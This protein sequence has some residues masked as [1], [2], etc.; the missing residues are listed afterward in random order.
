MLCPVLVGREAE[1]ASLEAILAEVV[2]RSGRVALVGGDAGI[3]KSRLLDAFLARAR[4]SGARVV[5]GRCAQAEARRPFGP[6]IDSLRGLRDVPRLVPTEGDL[7][8]ADPDVRY[9]ALRSFASVLGDLARQ[10]PLVV[11]IDDLQWADDATMDLFAYLARALHERQVLL[12]ASYRTDELH[13]LHPLRGV[14]AAL[15]QARLADPVILR[16]LTLAGTR[17][18]VEA[19][20]GLTA[21]APREL[22]TALHERCEGNPFFT[23]EVLRALTETG[24]LIWRHGTWEHVGR[25]ADLVIPASVRDIVQERLAAL[26]NE[27]RV[28]LRVAAVIGISFDFPLLQRLTATNDQ[29]LTDALRAAVAAQLLEEV[30]E[31]GTDRFQF[32][33]ALTRESVLADLLGRERRELHREVAAALELRSGSESEP[34]ELAYHFD[35]AGEREPAFRY[36]VRASARAEKLFAF[37]NARKHLERALELASTD[38]DLAELQLRFS[39]AALWAGDARGALRAAEEARDAYEKRGDPRGI[40]LALC[41]ISDADWYLGQADEARRVAEE[42]VRVLESLGTP[43]ELGDAYRRMAQLALFDDDARTDWAERTIEAARRCGQPATEVIGLISLGGALGRQGRAEALGY[44]DDALRLALELDKPDLVFRARLFLLDVDAKLGASPIDRRA[45]YV[46]MIEHARKHAFSTDQVL[47]ME[48]EEAIALG[49]FDEALRLAGQVTPDSVYGAANDLLVAV[50]HIARSGPDKASEVDAPRRRLLSA[51]VLWQTFA[52]TTAQVFLLADQPRAALEDAELAKEHLRAGSQR[53]TVDVAVIS[54]I[55]SARRLADDAALEGWIAI[56]LD[57]ETAAESLVR[58]ARRAFAGAERARREG[59]LGRALELS[60][61]SVDA[62]DH[63][64][65]PVIETVARLRHAEL[66]LER[67]SPEDRA[68]ASAELSKVVAFWRRA[69]APWY[70]GRLRDWAREHRLRLPAAPVSEVRS[71]GIL[72][73]RE[74]EVAALVTK[75]LTNRQIGERLVISERTVESH[76]ERIMDKLSKHTRAEIAAWMSAAGRP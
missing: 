29:E 67:G 35:E 27:T 74:R 66:L 47:V 36:H 10:D 70:L 11:A 73:R 3:G 37:R 24:E 65:W 75:G 46:E 54:A 13:R 2:T 49:D 32:R 39:R 60:A 28:A 4:A 52:T 31:P 71:T 48:V 42:S 26:P 44:L 30:S 6:F 7:A 62:L 25:M 53:F 8:V 9:R 23:E 12:V 22:I 76:V 21:S 59:D 55:E 38:V 51:P 72:T 45:L 19:T 20:L 50:I 68:A 63:C 69:S 1:L 16:P 58:R 18:M 61:T 40:A 33:H 56:A 43:C 5:L 17:E 64:Q 41:E 14:L 57:S 34:E 15:A